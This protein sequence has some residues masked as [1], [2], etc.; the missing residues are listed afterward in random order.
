LIVA[1]DGPAAAGKTS[2]ARSLASELGCAY[3]DTGAIYRSVYA[4]GNSRGIGMHDAEGMGEIA[5]TMSIEFLPADGGQRII[6]DGMDVTDRIREPDADTGSSVVSSHPCVREAL[7]GLQ[8]SF[9]ERG[10]IVCEGRDMCTSVFPDAEVKVYMTADPR[11]RA[12]R[13]L[14]QRRV[15]PVESIDPSDPELLELEASIAERDR[16]DSQRGC[17]PLKP[18]DGAA[19]IDTSSMSEREVLD[20]LLALVRAADQTGTASST[21]IA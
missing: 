6:A 17:S 10:S 12:S 21:S 9:A 8:R 7:M 1:I 18:A 3:L 11:T 19:I 4:V 14:A 5:H 20:V 15:V 16:R 2:A 13:R